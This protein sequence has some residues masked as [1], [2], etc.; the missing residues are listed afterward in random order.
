M[1]RRRIAISVIILLMMLGSFAG[2]LLMPESSP[3]LGPEPVY[4]GKTL[5]QW[6]RQYATDTALIAGPSTY[7]PVDGMRL[8]V[9]TTQQPDPA[10]AIAIRQMGTNALPTLFAMLRYEDSRRVRLVSR[11]D[12]L[13][14]WTD[15]TQR[16]RYLPPPPMAF[17]KHVDGTMGLY[18]LGQVAAPALRQALT[19]PNRRVREAATNLLS[20]LP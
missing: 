6:R 16:M 18:V 19:D 11:F 13:F 5:S 4:Q 8:P 14:G 10:P 7:L 12:W 15:D 9:P 20:K 17:Y 3:L 2:W 1:K